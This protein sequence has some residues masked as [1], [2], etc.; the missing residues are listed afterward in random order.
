[1]KVNFCTTKPYKNNNNTY[2]NPKCEIPLTFSDSSKK[3]V[4]LETFKNMLIT[5]ASL[6]QLKK[7]LFV[8]K[9][10]LRLHKIALANA[11]YSSKVPKYNR[12]FSDIPKF[13]LFSRS[14]NDFI[15]E[16]SGNYKDKLVDILLHY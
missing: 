16:I 12:K 2:Q 3:K 14:P 4:K 7:T 10:A 8:K 11:Y 6:P 13:N 9:T 1:M 5:F 15:Q